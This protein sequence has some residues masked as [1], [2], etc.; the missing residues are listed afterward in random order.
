MEGILSK[1]L[2]EAKKVKSLI[3]EAGFIYLFSSIAANFFPLFKSK[4]L[5]AI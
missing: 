1:E 3:F 5:T 4:R 2:I